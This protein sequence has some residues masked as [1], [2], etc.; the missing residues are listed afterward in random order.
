MPWDEAAGRNY[1]RR[2][3]RCETDLTDAEWQAT[4]PLPSGP[5]RAQPIRGRL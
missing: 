2:T 4:E 1:T 3:D 5:V